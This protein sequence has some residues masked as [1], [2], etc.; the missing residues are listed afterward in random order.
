MSSLLETLCIGHHLMPPSAAASF[1]DT[2]LVITATDGDGANLAMPQLGGV[3]FA[4][5]FFLIPKNIHLGGKE[6]V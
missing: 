3:L 4:R 6:H 2:D 5:F 1:R